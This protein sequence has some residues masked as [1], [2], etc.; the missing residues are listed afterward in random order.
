VGT[1][2]AAAVALL[3]VVVQAEVGAE[4]APASAAG[5][6]APAAAV[7]MMAVMM[8]MAGALG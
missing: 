8:S 4:L 7:S 3:E 2:A 5:K 1:T 6:I